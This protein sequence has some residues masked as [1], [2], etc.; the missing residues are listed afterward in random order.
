MSDYRLL[1]SGNPLEWCNCLAAAFQQSKNCE[2][3]GCVP[4]SELVGTA[5]SLYPDVILWKVDDRD[6]IQE[7]IEIKDKSP[8]SLTVIM[9]HDPR[10][11]NLQELVEAGMRGCLP[12]RLLPMQVVSAVELIVAAGVLCL[13]R[14]SSGFL[15]NHGSSHQI[16]VLGKLTKRELDV[17]ELLNQNL[18]IAGGSHELNT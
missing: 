14:P 8:L 17:L 2:V 18:F 11:Y 13:P 10:E 5:A 9:V 16:S 12:L 3:V 7:I 6:P 1:I 4:L 15:K